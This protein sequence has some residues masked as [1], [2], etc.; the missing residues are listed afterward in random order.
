MAKKH[1]KKNVQRKPA[2][3]TRRGDKEENE[4]LPPNA[5]RNSA[6]AQRPGRAA[7]AEATPPSP[8][9]IE[10]LGQKRGNRRV[11]GAL[12]TIQ[13]KKNKRKPISTPV[14]EKNK[15]NKDGSVTLTIHGHTVKILPD[16]RTNKKQMTNKA[17][18]AIRYDDYNFP[19]VK[20]Q[21]GKVVAI[22]GDA[23]VKHCFTIRTIYGPKVTA[24]SESAYGRGT[25]KEDVAAGDTSLGF[26]EGNH[27]LDFI[28]HLKSE[29]LPKPEIYVGMSV[30]DYNAAI[31]TYDIALKGYVT[32]MDNASE[33]KTDCVGEKADFCIEKPIE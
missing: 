31:R 12:S 18:T 16:G 22:E 8:E 7:L 15:P 1:S 27:G 29:P 32:Q 6:N 20:K 3:K 19:K 10:Q 24:E 23:T 5:T 2:R 25:T 14:G 21:N 4:M 17:E 9:E 33:K 13:A 28:N 26:H 11:I 30:K